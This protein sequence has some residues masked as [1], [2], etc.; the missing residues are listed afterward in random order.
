LEKVQQ[1]HTFEKTLL[2]KVWQNPTSEVGSNAV[3][4]NAN[5]VV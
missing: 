5:A 4:A 3:D 2:R 1:K